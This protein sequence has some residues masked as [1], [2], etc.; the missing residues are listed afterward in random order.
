MAWDEW[1]QM[2]AAAAERHST[3]MQL[4]QMVPDSGGSAPASGA[5]TGTGDDSGSLRHT[6]GP[7]GRAADTADDLKTSTES[8]KKSLQ[9]SH[10]GVSSGASGLAS[11]SALKTVLTSWENRLEAVRDECESLDPKLRAVAKDMGETDSTVA[12]KARAVHVSEGDK[13]Q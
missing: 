10:T 6:N 13:G 8:T 5:K 9:S 1:E 7:W 11:L 3:H 12:A 2:K 4:N